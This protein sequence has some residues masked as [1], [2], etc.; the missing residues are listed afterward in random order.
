MRRDDSAM[1]WAMR[2]RMPTTLM[3]STAVLG[4]LPAPFAGASGGRAMKAS[5]SSWVMRCSGPE[6]RT[7]R[8]STPASRAFR[9]TAGEASGFSP[10]GRDGAC[11]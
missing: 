9:R 2:R 10:G 11:A 6:P 7:K 8:R 3:V 1:L 5:R 4:A